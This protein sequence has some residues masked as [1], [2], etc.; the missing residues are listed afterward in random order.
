MFEKI[1]E[2]WSERI[3]RNAVESELTHVT[4]E[5][6]KLLK[7][8][9][10]Y[11]DL[12]RKTK[13]TEKVFL[14]RSLLPLGDWARIYPPLNE[15]GTRI[16]LFNLLFGGWRNLIRLIVI[17]SIIGFIIV[18]YYQDITYIAYLKDQLQLCNIEIP[19]K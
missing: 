10:K 12:P 3:Q 17:L 8:G 5:G 11:E 1:K 2:K 15:N 18:Q 13:V 16:K 4:R 9:V 6:I 14:K 19:L 7:K